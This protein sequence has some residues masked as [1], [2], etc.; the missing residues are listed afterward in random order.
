[1]TGFLPGC[2]ALTSSALWVLGMEFAPSAAVMNVINEAANIW[3]QTFVRRVSS[4]S[5]SAQW[6]GWTLI[7]SLPIRERRLK[8]S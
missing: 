7:H 8:S 6:T 1:M 3:L 5:P 2:Q 4:T